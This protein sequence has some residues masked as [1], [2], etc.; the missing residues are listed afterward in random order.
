MVVSR[1]PEP[2]A[3]HLPFEKYAEFAR[4]LTAG[5]T[6]AYYHPDKRQIQRFIETFLL[7]AQNDA[8]VL[9][10]CQGDSRRFSSRDRIKVDV[11]DPNDGRYTIS[12]PSFICEKNG[13]VDIGYL[14]AYVR[15]IQAS[16]VTEAAWAL[17]GMYFLSRC[18]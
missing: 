5:N 9:L 15:R 11:D 3:I 12:I 2:Y 6:K 14:E 13:E 7:D 1:K 8:K 4:E 16:N 18:R 10:N 17:L